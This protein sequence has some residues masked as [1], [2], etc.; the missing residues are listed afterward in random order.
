MH[1]KYEFCIDGIT[2]HQ[3]LLW[4]ISACNLYPISNQKGYTLWLTQNDVQ[5]RSVKMTS[6]AG[7]PC[8][9]FVFDADNDTGYYENTHGFIYKL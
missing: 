7:N 9:I 3:M 8:H 2:E 4:L 1:K 6:K 5:I